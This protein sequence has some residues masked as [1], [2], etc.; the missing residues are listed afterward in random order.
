MLFVPLLGHLAAEGQG[1][2][3]AFTTSARAVRYA[4]LP[5]LPRAW[6][7]GASSGAGSRSRL[8]IGDASRWASAGFGFMRAAVLPGLEPARARWS[9]CG[10]PR[11]R[12]CRRPNEETRS[13]SRRWLGSS[14]ACDC[15]QPAT[16]APAR[17]AFTCR[18]TSSSRSSNVSPRSIIAAEG[19]RG[20]R[21]AARARSAE[22]C[23]RSDFPDL[24]G[25]RQAAAQ[26]S[27][28][29]VS[30]AVPRA[31][32][33]TPAAVRAIADEVK[34]GDA[35]QCRTRAASTTTGTRALKRLRLELDQDQARAP[36]ALSTPVN[37]AA[38]RS[39][40][41]SGTNDRPVSR[42]RPADRHRAAP[43]AGRARRDDAPGQRLHRRRLS[44]RSVPLSQLVKIE[45]RL[46][47]RRASGARTATSRSPCRATSVEAS[48]G[49]PCR[50]QI[51]PPLHALE[52]RASMPAGL[53][54]SRSPV[55]RRRAAKAGGSIAADMPL[56][57]FIVFTLLMLQL[58]CFVALD[59][60][61]P[62]RTARPD[63]RG[64]GAAACS[65]RPFGFVALLGVIA[66]FGMI[67]RNS[68][69]LVDQIEQRPRPTACRPGTRSSRRRC[70]GC[71]RSC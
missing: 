4:V 15:V 48:K 64:G 30:G 50:P 59:A 65:S 57:L 41:L 20:A 26:R 35:R 56:M 62:D 40:M 60:G 37:G 63:R 43:A 3:P 44:G 55:P 66:L 54:A 46:G 9:T 11:A 22:L 68:V 6:S 47:A 12:A 52:L 32:A 1:P 16:S 19:P 49:P 42:E 45:L 25:A 24:R 10:C 13:A 2:R 14:R 71:G 38:P 33:A 36:S 5:P 70:A 34:D 7:T 8:T 28:G 21:C 53:P 17:R 67:I 31:G 39:T 27:S 18:W 58:H 69:I 29:A 61:V 23:S 51:C